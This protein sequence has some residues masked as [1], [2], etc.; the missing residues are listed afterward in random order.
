[1]TVKSR[2]SVCLTRRPSSDPV[3]QQ[4]EKADGCPEMNIRSPVVLGYAHRTG[5]EANRDEASATTQRAR[6]AQQ[7]RVSARARARRRVRSIDGTGGAPR[8]GA[9]PVCSFGGS[10]NTQPGNPVPAE[11]VRPGWST[12]PASLGNLSGR[13]TRPA[14]A[15]ICRPHDQQARNGTRPVPAWRRAVRVV[16]SK[17]GGSTHSGWFPAACVPGG[18]QEMPARVGGR[19]RNIPGGGA[20]AWCR[21]RGDFAEWAF[22]GRVV[23]R[24]VADERPFVPLHAPAC[25]VSDASK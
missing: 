3:P 24:L 1:M 18:R 23:R 7:S 9:G 5:I 17:G 19:Y 11:Q 2:A 25:A 13:N 4:V 20:S 10:Q 16:K 21:L 15:G 12:S 6:P 14:W 22:N 8:C